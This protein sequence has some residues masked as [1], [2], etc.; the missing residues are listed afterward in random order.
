[1]IQSAS[2]RFLEGLKDN[3]QRDWFQEHRKAY[4][5]ARDNFIAFTGQV[6]HSLAEFDEGIRASELKPKDFMLRIFRDVRFSKDKSPYKTNFFSYIHAGPKK[7]PHAGYY[8]SL[9]PGNSFMGGGVYM[10]ASQHLSR[11]RQEIDYNLAE[12]KTIAES[13][14]LAEHF[15]GGIQTHESLKRPP[16]GYQADNPAIAYLKYKGFYTQAFLKDK[17]LTQEG[18]LSQMQQKYQTLLPLITFLNRAILAE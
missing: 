1:M 13:E 18:I 11:I 3:N 15:P 2:L 6:M 17:E 4:E 12:W 5:A 8:L 14:K 16:K 7:G 10:P 9:E